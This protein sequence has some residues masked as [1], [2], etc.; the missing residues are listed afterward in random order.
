MTPNKWTNMNLHAQ[1]DMRKERER[2]RSHTHIL[3]NERFEIGVHLK[4][5]FLRKVEFIRS[6]SSINIKY[7]I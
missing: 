1:R 4:C 5:Y 6:F 3:K 2:A 7:A